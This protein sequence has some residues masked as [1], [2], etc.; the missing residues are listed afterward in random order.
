MNFHRDRIHLLKRRRFTDKPPEHSGH[1]PIVL[2]PIYPHS[3]NS[4]P[5]SLIKFTKIGIG[6]FYILY[7]GYMTPC[8]IAHL[9]RYLSL[10]PVR[11]GHWH[12]RWIGVSSSYSRFLHLLVFSTP[13]NCTYLYK[14]HCPVSSPVSTPGEDN[15]LIKAQYLYLYLLVVKI[16]SWWLLRGSG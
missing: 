16:L 4:N 14:W 15:M 8:F 10:D 3:F 5:V 11:A 6:Y 7:I 13:K 2:S 9:P 12:H 1:G